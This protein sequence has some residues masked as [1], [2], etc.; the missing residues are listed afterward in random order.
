MSL[1]IFCL[2]LA[3]TFTGLAFVQVL[4]FLWTAVF[5]PDTGGLLMPMH[6]GSTWVVFIIGFLLP[7]FLYRIFQQHL[8]PTYT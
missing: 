2:A 5:G 3:S 8:C 4:A 1:F 7:A 6:W